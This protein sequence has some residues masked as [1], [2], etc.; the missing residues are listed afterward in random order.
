MFWPEFE[1]N[2]LYSLIC[3]IFFFWV[4]FLLFSHRG[5]AAKL[6]CKF[7]ILRFFCFFFFFY[8]FVFFCFLFFFLCFFLLFIFFV[9]FCLFV[10]PF[11]FWENGAVQ[12][13][14][15]YHHST[16][17]QCYGITEQMLISCTA[18]KDVPGNTGLDII[19]GSCICPKRPLMA[20]LSLLSLRS[21][22]YNMVMMIVVRKENQKAMR[23]ARQSLY[24]P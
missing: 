17:L 6:F 5:Q 16:M 1:L 24:T 22:A 10:F 9:F 21:L 11:V 3:F 18:D 15:S 13:Q 2:I 7:Q 4:G 14:E 19:A 12:F 23:K 8:F 20:L